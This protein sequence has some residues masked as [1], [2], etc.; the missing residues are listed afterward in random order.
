MSTA[1]GTKVVENSDRTSEIGEQ[2]AGQTKEHGRPMNTEHQ[3]PARAV[4]VPFR[5]G[6][7]Q[8]IQ[9]DGQ[10]WVVLKPAC[11]ALGIDAF[12]QRK[13]LDQQAWAVS[14]VKESTGKDGKRYEMYCLRSD[15]LAMWLATLSVKRVRPELRETLSVWQCEAAGVLARHF[16]GRAAPAA[17]AVQQPL[18]AEQDVRELVRK[19]LAAQQQPQM[20]RLNRHQVAAIVRAELA[21]LIQQKA[22]ALTLPKMEPAAEPRHTV[23]PALADPECS[24]PSYF[25]NGIKVA[26]HHLGKP[27][28]AQ[29]IL[30]FAHHKKST[31]PGLFHFLDAITFLCTTRGLTEAQRVGFIC[32]TNT[33]M[34]VPAVVRTAS[35]TGLRLCRQ[36]KGRNGVHWHVEEVR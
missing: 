13:R 29:Q 4:L 6:A 24:Y 10:A 26:V 11:E 25:V 18:F 14:S 28:T 1:V 36:F 35:C 16:A 27:A 5:A 17:P 3:Q 33:G 12:A 20:T 8:C 9:S 21:E 31:I 23:L 19:E 2:V 15:V 34:R 22:Q 7:I 32:R 30:E